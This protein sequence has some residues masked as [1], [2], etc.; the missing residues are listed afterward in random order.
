M[1]I[2]VGFFGG[3]SITLD[4][5]AKTPEARQELEELLILMDAIEDANRRNVP[6]PV[7][8][9]TCPICGEISP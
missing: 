2:K 8:S 4:E 3:R 6:S 5:M 9:S 1:S 7:K